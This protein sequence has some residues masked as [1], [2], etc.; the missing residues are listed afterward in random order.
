LI[1]AGLRC[2]NTFQSHL[3]ALQRGIQNLKKTQEDLLR[4]NR[5]LE[6][7]INR[8]HNEADVSVQPSPVKSGG[9]GNPSLHVKV[10]ELELEVRRLKKVTRFTSTIGFVLN[11]FD[12]RL[13]LWTVRRL[14]RQ[15][16]SELVSTKGHVF[17][18]NCTASTER[19]P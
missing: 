7:E 10:K 13:V 4:K 5:R 11:L 3:S 17:L 12:I 15:V 18:L 19:S 2:K 16:T 8:L 1:L 14:N 9:K 6:Q